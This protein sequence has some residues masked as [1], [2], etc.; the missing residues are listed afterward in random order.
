M[1][2]P[3]RQERLSVSDA[4]MGG[5]CLRDSPTSNSWRATSSPCDVRARSVCWWRGESKSP[6]PRWRV[7]GPPRHLARAPQAAG[8]LQLQRGAAVWAAL[9]P[10]AGDFLVS[11]QQLQQPRLDLAVADDRHLGIPAGGCSEGATDQYR[12]Q[13][14]QVHHR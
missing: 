13:A 4:R 11:A 14:R 10:L 1:W 9:G 12:D 6:S 2:P 3:S 7:P 5:W 8:L